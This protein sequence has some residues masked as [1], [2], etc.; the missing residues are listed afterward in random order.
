MGEFRRRLQ[1]KA[2]G[3][4]CRV[5][6]ADRFFSSR[7]MCSSRGHVI[8]VLT[9]SVRTGICPPCAA[10]HDCDGNAAKKVHQEAVS[11]TA[12]ACGEMGAD[13]GGNT[14][15]KPASTKQECPS[16]TER[17]LGCPLGAAPLKCDRALPEITRIERSVI[18]LVSIQGMALS[19]KR[20]R[21]AV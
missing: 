16:L 18:G 11:R 15:V 2:V 7:K 9:L 19:H 10:V 5:V 17:F 3:S 8:D 21:H 4:G 12:S 6:V 14:R 20:G 1:Y 13:A